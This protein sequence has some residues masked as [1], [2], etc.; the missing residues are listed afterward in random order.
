MVSVVLFDDPTHR[1]NASYNHGNSTDSGMPWR[2][3]F[4]AC[5]A[6]GN[7]IRSYCEAGDPFCSV[8]PEANA[9]THVTYL[10]RYSTDV[11]QFVVDRYHNGSVSNGSSI[12]TPSPPTAPVIVSESGRC[13]VMSNLVMITALL[14]LGL[15]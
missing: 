8:G 10:D 3:D 15:I 4:S 5:D 12:N 2:H 9:L 13:S 6:L 14:V 1:S 11:A 7:R